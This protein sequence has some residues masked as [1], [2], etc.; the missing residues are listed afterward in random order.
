MFRILPLARKSTAITYAL[1]LLVVSACSVRSGGAQGLMEY[2]GLMAMPKNLPSAGTIN[3]M[4][5][6]YSK[7]SLP[8]GGSGGSSAAGSVMSAVQSIGP[9]GSITID[10]KKVKEISL[11]AEKS[12]QTALSKLK[13]SKPSAKDL[14]EAETALRETITLRNSVWGYSDP[15]MPILLNQLGSV[16]E[17]QGQ[18]ASAEACYRNA[19]VYQAKKNGSSYERVPSLQSLGRL[20]EKQGKLKEA[21]DNFNQVSQL[22]DRQDGENSNKALKARLD[23]ARVSSL[24]DKAD[25]EPLFEKCLKTFAA[26]PESDPGKTDGSLAKQ[27]IESYGGYLSKKG[28]TA[29]LSALNE[30]FA[31]KS[32]ESEVTEKQAQENKL[33]KKSDKDET[34][35]ADPEQKSEK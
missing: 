14:K 13:I 32:A 16:Y 25:T 2:G 17:K 26:L 23:L 4:T 18:T 20:Y 27:I 3:A 28:K 12:Y 15:S 29:E 30:R 31:P 33:D 34:V 10:P 22:I 35:K 1:S 6:P 19:L 11:K 7:L 9:D 24:L 21:V 8:G 5:S